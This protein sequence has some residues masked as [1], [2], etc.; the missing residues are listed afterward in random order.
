[1]ENENKL[2]LCPFCNKNA[3]LMHN[4]YAAVGSPTYYVMCSGVDCSV[5]TLE[6]LYKEDAVKAWNR[7]TACE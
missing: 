5:K 4:N 1:M 7:R 6:Y 2:L 3:E